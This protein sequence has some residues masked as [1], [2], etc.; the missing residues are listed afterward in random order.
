MP[1]NACNQLIRGN[2][3]WRTTMHNVAHVLK[4]TPALLRVAAAF[5][6]AIA[7]SAVCL[8]ALPQ[9]ALASDDS[10]N[11]NAVAHAGLDDLNA[12]SSPK[13]G[14]ATTQAIMTDR[15]YWTASYGL[16]KFKQGGKMYTVNGVKAMCI[17]VSQWQSTIDWTQ[18]KLNGIDYVIIRCGYGD[19]IKSQDDKQWLNNVKGAQKNGIGI[20]VYL[21][22]YANTLTKSTNEAK[23]TLRCLKDA[24]L[25]PS[26]LALP[27]YYDVEDSKTI[28]S[29]TTATVGKYVKNYCDLVAAEGYKVGVYASTSV[30]KG[31][32]AS[33][34]VL[35]P[36]NSGEWS[37]WVAHYNRYCGVAESLPSGTVANSKEDYNKYFDIWQ[38]SD[39]GNVSGI[40]G[41][42][43]MD[44][45]FDLGQTSINKATIK[46]NYTTFTYTGERRVPTVTVT[47]KGE[48]LEE[49]VDYEIVEPEKS[50]YVG[51]YIMKV[52]GIGEFT[53]SKKITYTIRPQAPVMEKVTALKKAFRVYWTPNTVQTYGYQVRYS[54]TSG[55]SSYTTKTFSGIATKSAKVS[56]AKA[57]TRYYVKVR[58][59]R[60]V[61]GTKYYSAWSPSM[62]VTTK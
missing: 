3:T 34:T 12:G 37:R 13:T 4:N 19:D 51:S 20:G 11:Q 23:H 44:Y 2:I 25:S 62:K 61:D 7:V 6:C 5:I 10:A 32:L 8:C 39:Q 53:S 52:K 40:S 16:T 29:K 45:I 9:P 57:K 43:D 42:V 15:P 41:R 36:I 14:A 60:T 48:T 1:K 28:L 31:K 54:R 46:T 17:D 56:V 59:Y 30:W 22:S 27:V 26:D 47:Y 49:G 33:A 35:D 18:V 24:G 38:F 55:F 50:T 21:F 58:A